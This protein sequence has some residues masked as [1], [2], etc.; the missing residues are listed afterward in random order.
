[1]AFAE[2]VGTEVDDGIDGWQRRRSM[3]VA[4]SAFGGDQRWRRRSLM[5]SAMLSKVTDDG[6]GR[7]R[8]AP[9]AEVHGDGQRRRRSTATL[10]EGTNGAET[11]TEIDAGVC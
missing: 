7:W 2:Q 1:M 11:G 3:I 10:A 9:T 6:G 8:R 5:A 4:P